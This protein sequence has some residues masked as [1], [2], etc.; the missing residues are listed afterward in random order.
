MNFLFNIILILNKHPIQY[1]NSL[2]KQTI[3]Y[4]SGHCCL[5]YIESAYVIYYNLLH[6][7]CFFQC[8]FRDNG[9]NTRIVEQQKKKINKQYSPS[10]IDA[11]NQSILNFYCHFLKKLSSELV[12]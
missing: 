4:P 5:V 12:V 10:S 8:S 7:L 9:F 1:K 2:I 11:P 3:G 6:E